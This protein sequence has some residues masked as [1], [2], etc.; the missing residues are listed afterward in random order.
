MRNNYFT[1]MLM[2]A[3]FVG[4]LCVLCGT[5]GAWARSKFTITAP[6]QSGPQGRLKFTITR[7]DTTKMEAVYVR[8]ADGTA[9]CDMH[10]GGAPED[11]YFMPGQ[12]TYEYEAWER[13]FND[14][15]VINDV[16]Y[17]Y[18]YGPESFRTYYV[19]VL[20]I[21]GQELLASAERRID[22]GD[23]MKVDLSI[24]TNEVNEEIYLSNGEFATGLP[25]GKYIDMPYN[26]WEDSNEP[27][28]NG[29]YKITDKGYDQRRF[30]FPMYD[31]Y[32][33]FNFYT[34]YLQELDVTVCA[35]LGFTMHEGEDGYQ[36]VQCVLDGMAGT[37]HDPDD[38][39]GKVS[40]LNQAI[41]KACF[42]LKGGKGACTDDYKIFFPHAGN[43]Q[44]RPSTQTE[45]HT[46]FPRADTQLWQQRRNTYGIWY[47]ENATGSM[48][49][50]PNSQSTSDYIKVYF[51]AAGT[52]KDIWYVKD[53]F[54]RYAFLDRTPPAPVIGDLKMNYG[55][56]NPGSLITFSIPFREVVR[57]SNDVV[58]HTNW[59]DLKYKGGDGTSV[60]NF[61]GNVNADY[62][63]EFHLDSVSGCI[64]DL[65]GNVCKAEFSQG[66]QY[67][68]AYTYYYLK[69]D[70]DGGYW[71][72][73]VKGPAYFE[74]V[75]DDVTI[76][77]PKRDGYVFLGW[78]SW[79]IEEPVKDVVL[80]AG[81][82]GGHLF[83][84]HWQK[85]LDPE[86][87][88]FSGVT[89]NTVEGSNT[90]TFDG[91]SEDTVSIPLPL[92]AS[93]VVYNR[94]FLVGEPAAV[95]LPFDVKD[96]VTAIGGKFY[97]FD[98]VEFE[99]EKWVVTMRQVAE[100]EAN[101]PYLF[102]PE[103]EHLTFDL[104]GKSVIMQTEEKTPNT[105]NGWTF[106][107]TYEKKVWTGESTD[108]GF[109]AANPE[110]AVKRQFT[111]FGD[112]DYILPLRCYLSY[113]GE[114][115][116]V[117]SQR[118]KAPI[119]SLPDIIEI[120]FVDEDGNPVGIKT[121]K[122]MTQGTNVWYDLNGRRVDGTKNPQGIY[123]SGGKKIV[124]E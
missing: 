42:E 109:S 98:K 75:S 106:R 31:M 10:Y 39:N 33:K 50:K 12:K 93:Q 80:P 72:E 114:N 8:C 20:D 113:D 46:E 70:L 9:V 102:M 122:A 97:R 81:T 101:M 7:S 44:W 40:P 92:E 24:I 36:Y 78:T 54:M 30:T 56:K 91:S 18:Q 3:T 47:V 86:T 79:D 49:I 96:N 51:D 43:N 41:Y 13:S 115:S 16:T 64:T 90:V 19:E 104:N 21:T 52:G 71:P 63:T 26:P 89:I 57:C 88:E 74:P 76:P 87:D 116:P 103:E 5:G 11:V 69:Y 14:I 38:E 95:F 67:A 99:A 68:N 53:L 59:G 119:A 85:L 15:D 110:D 111:R 37:A 66:M 55:H 107:G 17:T 112:G 118:H 28:E 105:K 58:A 23:A 61:T 83:V 73:G 2:K 84:A 62:R 35:T 108:F 124:V 22:Y 100:L 25:E 4:I 27:D 94:D 1:S 32:K 123:V 48:F 60:L 77:Q 82:K 45:E 120:K 121:V 34:W 29:Y 65:V 6:A 117:A